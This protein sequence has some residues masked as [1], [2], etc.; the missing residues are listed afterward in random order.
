MTIIIT[1]DEENNAETFWSEFDSA[2]PEI[3]DQVREGA[4][5]I[6]NATWDAIQKLAGFADGPEYAR[7]PFVVV[8]YDGDETMN[9]VDDIE[10]ERLKKIVDDAFEK[11]EIHIGD[12][13][14]GDYGIL[15]R[16]VLDFVSDVLH[17]LAEHGE[18]AKATT[19][20]TTGKIDEA[21]HTIDQGV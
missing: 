11:H 13:F 1:A 12:R 8:C 17:R 6:D 20:T 21:C 19:N 9:A 18:G 3:A 10:P 7:T 15:K 16:D 2:Y 5:T 4:A 14:N